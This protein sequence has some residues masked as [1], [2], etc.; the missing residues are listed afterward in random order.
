MEMNVPTKIKEQAD[1]LIKPPSQ[2]METEDE[3][4]Q[5][6][7]ISPIDLSQYIKTDDIK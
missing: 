2:V 3:E 1:Q 4:D 6:D 5:Q 7:H